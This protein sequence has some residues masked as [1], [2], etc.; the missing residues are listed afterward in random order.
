MFAPMDALKAQEIDQIYIVIAHSGIFLWTSKKLPRE[1]MAAAK[2]AL[3]QLQCV[4]KRDCD[5]V[6]VVQAG[7]EP[8]EFWNS[9]AYLPLANGVRVTPQ[10]RISRVDPATSHFEKLKI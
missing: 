4:E 10:L 1:D 6:S 2:L 8:P 9:F 7:N 3:Q 5:R